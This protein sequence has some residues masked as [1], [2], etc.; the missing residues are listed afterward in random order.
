M[1]TWNRRQFL[2]TT[3][4]LALM[5]GQANANWTQWRGPSR[6][7][8]V[9]ESYPWPKT[10]DEQ[11]L[12]KVWE[13]PLSPSYS[14]P[15]VKDGTVFVTETVGKKD[16]RVT[17]F[18]TETGEQIWQ[19]SW[20]GA[21]KVPFFAA[22]NGS[23]IRS[24]PAVSDGHLLVGGIRDV[25]VCLDPETGAKI[26]TN[27]FVQT[28]NSKVPSFGF[29]SSPLI[30]GEFAFVQAGG[31]LLKI[32]LSTGKVI[33]RSLDDGG[34]MY[35]SAFSSP[36]FATLGGERQ[37]LVQTRE[38]LVG[39]N[40]ESGKKLWSV[41]VPAFRGMNILPP[42]PFKD[43]VFTSSYKN[44]SFGYQIVRS[45]DGQFSVQEKW[46]NR[47]AGYMSNPMVFGDYVYLHLGNGRLTCMELATGKQRW[48]SRP[49]GKYWSSIA[50]GNRML[51]LDERG[52]LLLV[53]PNKDSFN[54]I[55]KQKVA[56]NSW[57][58]L[59]MVGDQLFVRDLD[60]LT[61]YRWA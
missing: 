12:K 36:V 38:S 4:G 13:K 61:V 8:M 16:E 6:D 23:W 29:V 50:Q 18:N 41:K 20:A 35:G 22:S 26:W 39:V 57:A 5:S 25:L 47:A 60:K 44:G 31:A 3:A 2:T 33:W 54:L 15:I 58:H 1:N 17:A 34:G 10:L 40:A 56:S 30:E 7:G 42:T 9:D 28:Q 32:E 21:M 51:S 55:G 19:E 45:S 53:E 59:A 27:D 11:S 49:F 14:G 37:L 43:M 48:S 46:K 24:T 52:D